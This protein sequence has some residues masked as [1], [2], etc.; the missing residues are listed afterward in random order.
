MIRACLQEG[1]LP[2]HLAVPVRAFTNLPCDAFLCWTDVCLQEG[3][4]P[5]YFAAWFNRLDV[6]ALLRGH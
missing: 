2:I 3:M 1:M 4:L 5:I 6:A